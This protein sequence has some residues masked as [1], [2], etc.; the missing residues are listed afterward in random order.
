MGINDHNHFRFQRGKTMM[1]F[2][3]DPSHEPVN[4]GISSLPL[5]DTNLRGHT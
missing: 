1:D 3:L 5:L 2:F 4:L